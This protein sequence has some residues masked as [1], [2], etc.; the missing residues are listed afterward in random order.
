MIYGLPGAGKT[1]FLKRLAF[2]CIEGR[3]RPDLVPVFISLLEMSNS[4]ISLE[5]QISQD[6]RSAHVVESGRVLLLLDG[7]DEVAA[8]SYESVKNQILA[9]VRK[10]PETPIVMTC[11]IAARDYVFQEF[12]DVEMA[13]FDQNQIERFSKNWFESR[14]QLERAELFLT[15]MSEAPPIREL[16]SKPLLLALLC[17]IF[18]DGRSFDGPRG[19]LYGEALDVLIRRWDVS[20]DIERKSSIKPDLLELLLEQLAFRN[21]RSGRILMNGEKLRREIGDF[22]LSRRLSVPAKDVLKTL[23][24]DYG[25]IVTRAKDWYCFSHL[26]FQ[27]YLTARCV[28]RDPSRLDTIATFFGDPKWREVWLLLMNEMNGDYVIRRM[29][30]AADELLQSHP[31]LQRALQSAASKA[32]APESANTF[33]ERARYL[34]ILTID[35]RLLELAEELYRFGVPKYDRQIDAGNAPESD[36]DYSLILNLERALAGC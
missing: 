36:L 6:T 21:F 27:E 16:G 2:E 18:E 33:R 3:F 24:G 8:R 4:S 29:K 23:E 17:L 15:R 19:K 14:G 11:R 32:S 10:H 20:R 25:L 31:I 22:F 9:F 7:L 13:D 26:T 30:K 28:A 35:T 34:G 1:T 12:R 5:K